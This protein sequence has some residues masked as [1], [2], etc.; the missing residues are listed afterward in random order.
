[1]T[2]D[3][4]WWPVI[5]LASILAGLPAHFDLLHKAFP[6]LSTSADGLIEL[7]C[8]ATGVGAGVMNMSPLKISDQGRQEAIA[9]K[10]ESADTASVAAAVAASASA[11]AA[12]AS[13][14]AV[15]AAEVANVASTK[16]ADPIE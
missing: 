5:I 1:M 7:L 4:K 12:D 6:A 10:V 11:Q 15:K 2:R 8:W 9:K 3:S 14:V 16:A 13:K